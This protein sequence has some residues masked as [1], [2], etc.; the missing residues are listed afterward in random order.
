MS[1]AILYSVW[2]T[3][4]IGGRRRLYIVTYCAWRA[5]TSSGPPRGEDELNHVVYA[6]ALLHAR[7]DGR[8]ISSHELGI[9]VHDFEGCAD[10]RSQI[11]LASY[12]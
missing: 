8:A 3:I 12:G 1:L 7:E 10:V 9:A 6:V 11:D 5:G 2:L 4:P